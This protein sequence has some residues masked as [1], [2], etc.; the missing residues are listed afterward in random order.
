MRKNIKIGERELPFEANLGTTRLYEK[1]TGKNILNLMVNFRNNPDISAGVQMLDVFIKLAYVMNTQ[2]TNDS[3]KEMMNRMTEDQEL[4]WE[5]Q[6][7]LADFNEEV[8]TELG[9]LFG[10]TQK[11]HSEAAE[12]N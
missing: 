10:S 8:L 1:L 2:A 3:I 4:E 6:F 12:K 5:F 9:G 11:T 7:N